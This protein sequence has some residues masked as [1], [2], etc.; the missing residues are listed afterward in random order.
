MLVQQFF[1]NSLAHC[2]F[3][4]IKRNLKTDAFLMR[5]RDGAGAETSLLTT[6]FNLARMILILG[7]SGLIQKLMDL[8]VPMCG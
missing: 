4:H 2:S 1:I 6:C 5:G 3:D 8:S 7:V